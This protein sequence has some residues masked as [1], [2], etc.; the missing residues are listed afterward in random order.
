[1]MRV[2]KIIS[3]AQTGA[4]R[5]ALD[6]AIA[7]EIPY[8]GWVPAGRKAEDGIL[9]DQYAV[10]E[11]ADG[12]YQERTEKNV[13]DSDGTLIFSHGELNGGSRLTRDYAEKH[14]K[15]FLHIDFS[16]TLAFDA[17]ID[18][19]DWIAEHD[20]QILN[21]AGPRASKDPEI[22]QSVFKILETVFYVSVISDA[23]PDFANRPHELGGG[24]DAGQIFPI[25]VKEALDALIEQLSPKIKAKIASMP[26]DQLSEAGISL[27]RGIREQFG[28]SAGNQKLID[29]CRTYAGKPNLDADGAAM[30][31]V[32]ELWR[33]LRKMGHLRVIK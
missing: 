14:Q 9:S 4:D 19:N 17:A 2:K 3:G 21:V 27:G 6:F 7:Y 30:L 23:M 26:D 32:R 1:M 12:G 20:I 11:M 18:I 13:M 25:T 10:W 16:H 22:Y 15:P 33:R 31:I 24:E 29:A 28:L 5:A 8:G